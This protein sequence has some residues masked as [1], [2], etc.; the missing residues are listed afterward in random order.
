MVLVCGQMGRRDYIL[1]RG[2]D[3]RYWFGVIPLNAIG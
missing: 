2:D 1:L 3:H